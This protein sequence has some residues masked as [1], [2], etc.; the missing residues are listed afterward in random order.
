MSGAAIDLAAAKAAIPL[1][2]LIGQT[3][4]LKRAGRFAV[5]V[6]PFHD[7]KTPSFYVYDDHFHC[8]GCGAHGDAFDWLKRTR[9]LALPEAAKLLLGETPSGEQRAIPPP[10]AS[11][12]PAPERETSEF[13]R[14]IWCEAISAAGTL[15][16]TYL[17]SRGLTL[18]P[19]API[20]FHA[21]CPRGAERFPA[22][23]APMTDPLTGE[24]CGVHRTFLRE[25]GCGKASGQA[26]MMAGR[27]GVVRLVPDHEVT[28]GLGLAEGIE[29][30]LAIMEHADWLD[31][32]VPARKA[33]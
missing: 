13:G 20:R 10:R 31:A 17:A 18:P 11:R 9:G 14:Q 21:A 8:F 15:A 25:D 22:M 29:T 3:V 33:A 26:K 19:R 6:C 24:R 4:P 27:A 5:G 23:L 2:V 30:S 1:A 7:E 32:L 28:A 12:A 16:E